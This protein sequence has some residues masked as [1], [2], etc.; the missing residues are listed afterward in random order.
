MK[1]NPLQ[2]GEGRGWLKKV[3]GE[4]KRHFER[5]REIP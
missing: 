3:K 4:R 1:K 2:F 5:K